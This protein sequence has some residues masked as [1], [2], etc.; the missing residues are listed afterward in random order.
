MGGRGGVLVMG[1]AGVR[2][3]W[4]DGKW[5]ILEVMTSHIVGLGL[6]IRLSSH[7]HIHSSSSLC[8]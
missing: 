3:R 5:P 8:M 2:V 7:G 6:G 1:R 4:E